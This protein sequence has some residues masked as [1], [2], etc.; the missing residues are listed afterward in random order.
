MDHRAASKDKDFAPVALTDQE[1]LLDGLQGVLDLVGFIPAVGEVA[2]LLNAG[3]SAARGK[4]LDAALSLVSLIPGVGDVIGKGAKYAL[5]FA[6][7]VMARKAL[8][9]LAQ[10]DIAY[11]F[12]KLV[13]HPELK[14]Y[15]EPLRQAFAALEKELAR[16]AGVPSPRLAM[17]GKGGRSVFPSQYNVVY[18]S[19]TAREGYKR[20]D[21]LFNHGMT[22]LGMQVPSNALLRQALAQFTDCLTR[23]ELKGGFALVSN[24]GTRVA[25]VNSALFGEGLTNLRNA[26]AQLDKVLAESANAHYRAVAVKWTLDSLTSLRRAC[27][28][29]DAAATLLKG[30]SAS[31]ARKLK[32][33]IAWIEKELD[34]A[35]GD[36]EKQIRRYMPSHSE[37][38]QSRVSW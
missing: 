36:L 4:Y 6:D 19:S 15:V 32:E 29:S 16:I 14:K 26:W 24:K 31:E 38:G 20:G 12:H 10:A 9:A 1:G 17:A 27:F 22:K 7:P 2:D 25:D 8:S 37:V 33:Q 23:I 5:K 13:Q 21:H 18:M 3:I 28:D 30:R 34:S 11:F 35:F